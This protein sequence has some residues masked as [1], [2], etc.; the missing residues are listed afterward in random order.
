MQ[1]INK[2]PKILIVDDMTENIDVLMLFLKSD[3]M[4]SA[5]RNGKKAL[6]MAKKNKPDLILL[7]IIMPGMDGYEVCKKLKSNEETKNIPV[8]FITALT[9]ALDE[10]KA[11]NVGAVDYIPKPFIPVTVKAR[12]KTHLNLKMKTD[13]LEQLVALDGLTNIYNRRKFDE[14]LENEWNRALRKQGPISLMLID[15][16]HFK[17]FNDHYGHAN[18]DECLKKIAECMKNCFMRASDLVCRYGG[19]EFAVILPDTDME[20]ADNLAEIFRLGIEALNIKHEYSETAGHVTAS[21]G[22]VTMTPDPPNNNTSEL[23]EIVD[24]MLYKSKENGR[25]RVT[26]SNQILSQDQAQQAQS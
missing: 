10:A 14:M 1:Q 5:A 25:N 6:Q 26:A 15:I 9:E 11:F 19:E 16:D 20:G 7:D 21:I 17:L 4:V 2:K 12:I 18:G 24:K 8:I 23:I 13:M 3:Y 22:V